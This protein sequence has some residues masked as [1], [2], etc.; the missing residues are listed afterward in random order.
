SW[1]EGGD[2]RVWQNKNHGW[3]WPLINGAVREFEDVLESVGNPVDERHRRLLRQIA[4]E[5]LLMEGSDWPFLLYT[6]Q[7][8]EYANQRFHWHHQRFNTLMWAARDLNDPG[9]LGNR[10]LQEVEDIDKCFEL[11]DLDLFRHRE[12]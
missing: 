10:F 6:K 12:S 8:T 7:A 3:I 2:F 9:R 4:R 5:L 1:G 11:D